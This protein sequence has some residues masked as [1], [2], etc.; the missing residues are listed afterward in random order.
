MENSSKKQKPILVK[1]AEQLLKDQQE[2]DSLAV[3]WSL[4]KAEAKDKINEA[5]AE[6][7]QKIHDLKI[8]ISTEY[9]EN[10]EWA[11]T[12]ILKLN[13]LDIKLK[14]NTEEL[15]E[16]S[17]QEI[18]IA[19]EKVENQINKNPAAQKLS[20]LFSIYS[21]KVRLQFEV[22]EINLKNKKSEINENL[23]EGLGDVRKK[24]DSII[25]RLNEKKEET[26]LKLEGFKDEIGAVY[27]HLKKAFRSLN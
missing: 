6:L 7:K 23:N 8:W 15:F 11:K 4:G 10:S 5:K 14:E 19:V 1:I 24:I 16:T 25:E 13:D 26:D 2:L 9:D 27:D 21:E 17:K 3:Q 12:T 18:L 22:I 20:V